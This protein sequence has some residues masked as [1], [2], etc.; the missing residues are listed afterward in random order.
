[1]AI[2]AD[3]KLTWHEEGRKE[4]CRT[5]VF[6]VTERESTGPDGQKGRFVVNEA[7]DWVAV[8]PVVDDSFLMVRQWR[9]GE[10]AL[11]IEFPG[12]I[13]EKGEEPEVGARR[14]LKEETGAEAGKL[15]YLG[16]MN[17]NPA[18]FDNHMYF[19]CAQDLKLTG[20]Q[21]L[22]RDEFV[23]YMKIPKKEVFAK[24][25]SPEYPHALMAAALCLYRQKFGE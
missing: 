19:Y 8:I 13:I 7:P 5:P 4:I 6:T 23:N 25:G 1:M 22:D 17:P 11:S 10:Q 16:R 9:H 18:L 2:M 3:D 20:R 21:E 24:M 12:G 14:E 15:T